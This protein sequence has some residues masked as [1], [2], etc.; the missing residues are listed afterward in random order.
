L[1]RVLASLPEKERTL[2]RLHHLD[3]FTMDRLSVVYGESRSGIS[4]RLLQ[5]R[6]RLLKLTRAELSLELKSAPPELE[7]FFGLVR[8]RLELSLGALME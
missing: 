5:A 8:S 6:A 4:R 1:R 3:G 2:L 7:S